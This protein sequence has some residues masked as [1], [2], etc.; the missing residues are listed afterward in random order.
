MDYDDPVV[1]DLYR[2]ANDAVEAVAEP[3]QV[4][5]WLKEELERYA[6]AIGEPAPLPPEADCVQ[7]CA[8]EIRLREDENDDDKNCPWI[9]ICFMPGPNVQP[10]NPMEFARQL[11]GQSRA[12]QG[13][14]PAAYLS[15]RAK[16]IADQTTD[17]ERNKPAAKRAHQNIWDD[18]DRR[19][20]NRP[21]D[22][23][24]AALHR[25]DIIA[26]GDA[27]DFS[28][29]G[30]GRENTLIGSQWS[31]GRGVKGGDRLQRLDAHATELQQRGCP[32]MNAS[33][34]VCPGRGTDTDGKTL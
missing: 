6:D 32:Q 10:Y 9:V 33:L 16:V 29:I 23:S 31:Q 21:R 17:V 13:I 7:H 5:T 4:G 2:T 28:R 26:G 18:Y 11:H 34:Q 24:L 15:R 25:L 27:T 14:D 1:E 22:G 8:P 20:P 30:P 19:N 3:A 12:L